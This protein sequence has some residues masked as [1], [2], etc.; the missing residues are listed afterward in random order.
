MVTLSRATWPH[1]LHSPGKKQE[2]KL[3]TSW[4]W[5]LEE[6]G[7]WAS[8]LLDGKAGSK[9]GPSLSSSRLLPAPSPPVSISR[10]GPEDGGGKGWLEVSVAPD[11]PRTGL[12]RCRGHQTL[13]DHDTTQ[14]R[15]ASP[16]LLPTV[17]PSSGRSP[18]AWALQVTSGLL[19]PPPTSASAL[20]GHH[21]Q[22]GLSEMLT[23]LSPP[24]PN[25]PIS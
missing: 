15:S 10:A 3:Q 2:L 4:F 7:S 25:P 16:S 19:S 11:V 20:P 9:S 22:G 1:G 5:S 8:G 21:Q 17:T 6:P 14:P 13:E 12:V 24:A 18:L 23:W